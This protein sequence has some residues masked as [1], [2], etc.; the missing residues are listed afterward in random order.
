MMKFL[1]PLCFLFYSLTGQSQDTTM[2]NLTQGVEEKEEKQSVAIFNSDKIINANTTEPVG[3]GRMMFKVTHNFDDIGGPRGGL[4]NFF[5]LDASTDVRIGFHIGLTDRLDLHLARSK[6]AGIPEKTRVLRLWEI[7]L[8]YQLARQIENDPSHP[9]AISLFA[10]NVI[11]SMSA[12]YNAPKDAF[13]NST[14]TALNYPFTFTGFGKR[15]SQVVQLILAKKMGKI[16]ALL[17]FSLVNHAYVPLHDQKTVFAVGGGL[18]MP[19]TKN[20]NLLVD[21]FVPF[22]SESSKDYFEKIDNSFDAPTDIDRNKVPLKFYN[23]LG[24]GFEI[25]TPGHIFTLNFSNTTEILENRFIPYTTT[26]WT[27]SQFRWC[28]SISRKFVLKRDKS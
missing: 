18:R 15:M 4:K 17:N 9:I 16:S 11:S 26:T 19:L 23:P 5:G 25:L 20:F 12:S 13:G 6:G 2:N 7:A 3:K 10:N 8:K 24:I 22:R 27:K 28:F 1:F 21:Y 14:D